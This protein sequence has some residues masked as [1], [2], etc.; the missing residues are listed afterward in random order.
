MHKK[1]R[2]FNVFWTSQTAGPSPLDNRRTEIFLAGCNKAI[3]GNPC[4]GCFNPD[5]W[6]NDYVA[7]VTPTDAVRQIQKFAP[8]KFITFVGGEPLDQIIPLAEICRQL[9]KLDYHIIVFTHYE[10]NE[11]LAMNDAEVLLNSVDVIIDGEFRKDEIIYDR[12]A[13][14]GLRDAVGSGNQIIWD[15]RDKDNG[16]IQ[17]IPARDLFAIY[18]TPNYDLKYITRNCNY[19]TH[20]ADL[21]TIS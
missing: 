17:G 2:I 11:I 18:V 12:N 8:N 6:G 7:A 4:E 9:K 20:F 5:L 10:M 14:D 15:V 16:V 3:N 21:E 19:I 13:G 1:I